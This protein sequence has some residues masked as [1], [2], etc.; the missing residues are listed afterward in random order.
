LFAS[1]KSGLSRSR[2][3]QPHPARRGTRLFVEQLEARAL[4]SSYTAG[5]VSALITDI[6]AAN[7]A[8]GANTIQLTAATGPALHR[9]PIFFTAA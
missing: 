5:S 2:R 7:L 4:P 8:G 1:M 3:P 6:N 9:A